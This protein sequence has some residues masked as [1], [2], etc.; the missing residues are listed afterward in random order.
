MWRICGFYFALCLI[1]LSCTGGEDCTTCPDPNDSEL[2]ALDSAILQLPSDT[3]SVAEV[4]PLEGTDDEWLRL[5]LSDG[6]LLVFSGDSW[7]HSS[8]AL[9]RPDGA[10][11]MRQYSS[12]SAAGIEFATGDKFE[13]SWASADTILRLS[14]SITNPSSILCFRVVGDSISLDTL[15]SSIGASLASRSLSSGDSGI[16]MPAKGMSRTDLKSVSLD[17]CETNIDLMLEGVNTACSFYGMKFSEMKDK[18]A[19]A[20]KVREETYKWLLKLSNDGQ[21]PER[22][23]VGINQFFK[24]TCKL[25][26]F[27]SE[28]DELNALYFLD[29]ISQLKKLTP[30]GIACFILEKGG[31]LY[32]L[33]QNSGATEDFAAWVCSESEDGGDFPQ[34]ILTYEEDPFSTFRR[35]KYKFTAPAVPFP[36]ISAQIWLEAVDPSNHYY[37]YSYCAANLIPGQSCTGEF[38]NTEY[39]RP[40]E[41][42]RLIAEVYPVGNFDLRVGEA[43]INVPPLYSSI[44]EGELS[45][46]LDVKDAGVYRSLDV[47]AS[48]P[49]IGENWRAVFTLRPVGIEDGRPEVVIMEDT[50]EKNRARFKANFS[51]WLL[52]C[53]DYRVDVSIFNEIG[54][55]VDSDSGFVYGVERNLDNDFFS[56]SFAANGVSSGSALEYNISGKW[57]YWVDHYSVATFQLSNTKGWFEQLPGFLGLEVQQGAAHFNVDCEAP[58]S[59]VVSLSVSGEQQIGVFDGSEFVIESFAG[60]IQLTLYD[61]PYGDR[62]VAG[63]IPDGVGPGHIGRPIAGEIANFDMATLDGIVFWPF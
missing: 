54:E 55:F 26:E 37:E 51:W 58:G 29:R 53:A 32:A 50:S 19:A 31:D 57:N 45:L 22:V 41:A 12:E 46:V 40:C 52:H 8:V 33:W 30:F 36:A 17:D 9:K 35:I 49:C 62:V 1:F 43:E 15:C 63:F 13:L 28:H 23:V 39:I 4:S 25:I 5:L 2:S 61:S 10:V 59:M 24:E 44:A 14:S 38:S 47:I 56:G 7:T 20:C 21:I 27:A 18:I 42:Y 34:P 3:I 60:T 16:G 6:N 11:I 48:Y